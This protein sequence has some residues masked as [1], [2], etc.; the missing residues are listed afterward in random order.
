[1]AQKS[2]L[3]LGRPIARGSRPAL[4]KAP[5]PG[6]RARIEGAVREFIAEPVLFVGND[7]NVVADAP[8]APGTLG[9]IKWPVSVRRAPGTKVH[10]FS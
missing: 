5:G 1:V 3:Q 8:G 7:Q 9:W 2:V 6:H 10:G 4:G